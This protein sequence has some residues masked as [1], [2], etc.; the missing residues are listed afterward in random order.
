MHRSYARFDNIMPGMVKQLF[1]ASI[2]MEFVSRC[3]PT[4]TFVAHMQRER[5]S[6]IFEIKGKLQGIVS[7]HSAQSNFSAIVACASYIVGNASRSV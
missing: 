3:A 7:E 6:C 5:G 4:M 1:A 2:L